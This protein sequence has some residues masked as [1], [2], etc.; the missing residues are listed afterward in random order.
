MTNINIRNNCSIR[1][2]HLNIV[3]TIYFA[4]VKHSSCYRNVFQAEAVGGMCPGRVRAKNS[5]PQ[6]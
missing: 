1:Q 2:V 6:H 3:I 5:S 4:Y